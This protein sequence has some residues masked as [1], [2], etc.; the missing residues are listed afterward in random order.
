MAPNLL[1][2]RS[3]KHFGVDS[4]EVDAIQMGDFLLCADEALVGHWTVT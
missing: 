2:V 1:D 4:A 3:C